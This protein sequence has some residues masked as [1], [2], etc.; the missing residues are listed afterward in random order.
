MKSILKSHPVL[1][2]FIL[3]FAISW[4]GVLILGA[5]HGM[6]TTSQKFEQLYPIVF[7]PYLLG[8]LLSSLILT[9]LIDGRTGF[10]EL[11]SRLTTW[12][13]SIQWYA[14]AVLT[15]PVIILAVLGSLSLRTSAYLP[16]LFTGDDK[17]T[18]LLTGAAIGFFGGG[19]M[20]EP[21]WT[22]FAVPKLREHLSILK[23]G[24]LVGF[25]WGLW[26]FLPTYWGSG[27]AAGELSLALLLPPLVFYAAVLPAYRLLMIWVFQGTKSLLVVMLMHASLTACSLFI[28]APEVQGA[29]LVLYYLILAGLL[30][31]AAWAVFKFT[32]D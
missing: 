12:R 14:V 4:G 5:P 15:A 8:P 27:D 18:L 7:L 25:V 16:A 26:H 17:T 19:L 2:Y 11:L 32:Q 21:G 29:G 23:T 28:L 13:V 31:A 9:G 22:G 10:R 1:A 3:T 20:E 30:W 6:P 24:L